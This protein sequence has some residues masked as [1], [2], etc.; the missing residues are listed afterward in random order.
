MM[1][2][3][4][5]Y[6]CDFGS[7]SKCGCLFFAGLGKRLWPS[8]LPVARAVFCAGLPDGCLR[9]GFAGGPGKQMLHPPGPGDAER[10]PPRVLGV[11]GPSPARMSAL[12]GE[13][14]RP[15]PEAWGKQRPK[16]TSGL[17]MVL[18]LVEKGSSSCQ[19]PAKKDPDMFILIRVHFCLDD[20]P[21]GQTKSA[22]KTIKK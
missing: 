4:L 11:C 2:A 1:A 22:C 8:T 3:E 5:G 20:W 17:W 12:P 9:Q 14:Q 6:D 13:L 16:L 7:G 10:R 15:D 19:V 21:S 18:W